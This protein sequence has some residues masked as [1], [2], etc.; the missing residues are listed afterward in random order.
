MLLRRCVP[1]DKCGGT[2]FHGCLIT[3]GS[4][5][6]ESPGSVSGGR[7]RRCLVRSLARVV[8]RVGE[9][10]SEDPFPPRVLLTLAASTAF[11]ARSTASARGLG[12]VL[13]DTASG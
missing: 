9:L 13:H 10:L 3:K 7:Q 6:G 4:F 8:V 1:S 11:A 5:N 12:H 2:W